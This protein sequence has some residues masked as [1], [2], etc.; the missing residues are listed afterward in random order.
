MYKLYSGEST[1]Y[2]RV[3][4]I[5]EISTM[6]SRAKI[7]ILISSILFVFLQ[8]PRAQTFPARASATKRVD[9]AALRNADANSRDWLSYGRDYSETRFSPLK[10]INANTVKK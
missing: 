9:D 3:S 8:A 6:R 5:H 10:E 2:T 1:T 4:Q 7:P